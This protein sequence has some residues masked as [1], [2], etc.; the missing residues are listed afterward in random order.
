MLSGKTRHAGGGR[1]KLLKTSPIILEDLKR[2]V[3]PTTRGDP[4]SPLL[5]TCKSLRNLA[6]ELVA[7][8]HKISH[9]TVGLLLEKMGYILQVNR[10]TLERS[11]NPDL[12]AQFELIRLFK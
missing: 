4:G 5:W 1:K 9:P 3:E 6:T 12:N 11:D 8:G 7:L 10:K 2:L